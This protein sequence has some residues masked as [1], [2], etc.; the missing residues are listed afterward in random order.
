[1]FQV[2]IDF[3]TANTVAVVRGPD[4]NLQVKP[5]LGSGV[6]ATTSGHRLTGVDAERAGADDPA[7]YEGRLKRRVDDATVWLGAREYPVVDLIAAVLG[8]V[9]AQLPAEVEDAGPTGT[10]AP[11]P[12]QVVMTRPADWGRSRTQVLAEAAARAGLGPVTFVPEPVAAATYYHRTLGHELPPGKVLVV[13]DLGAGSSDVSIVR[14]T[15]GGYEVAG[16]AGLDNVGGLDLDEAIVAHVRHAVGAGNVPADRLGSPALREEVRRA[17]ERLAQRVTAD[18]TVPG[19]GAEVH[20]HRD[21]L[22]RIAGP[23]LDRTV[24]LT[25]SALQECQLTRA[26]VG[27]VFLVGGSSRIVLAAALLHSALGVTPTVV[28]HPELVLA[29]GA[30]LTLPGPSGRPGPPTVHSGRSTRERPQW[31]KGYLVAGVVAA[32]AATVG[33]VVWRATGDPAH[34][35]A[36]AS[37]AAPAGRTPLGQAP[38]GPDASAPATQPAGEPLLGHTGVVS[39][40]AFSPDGTVVLTGSD[41]RTARLWNRVENRVSTL[42]GQAKPVLGVAFDPKG[43]S[44]A[45]ADQDGSVWLWSLVN[46]K[47]AHK[48]AA[49]PAGVS[50]VAYSPDGSLIATGGADH[51]VQLWRTSDGAHV[52]T[53]T[54]HRLEVT[55]IAFNA[56]GTRLLSGSADGT[57]RLW[58]VSDGKTVRTFDGGDG[59]TVDGVAF[60]GAA[61]VATTSRGGMIRLW[62]AFSGARLREIAGGAFAVAFSP[63][64]TTLAAGSDDP[65]VRLWNASTGQL[66][67]TL[68][69]HTGGVRSLAFSRDGKKLVSGSADKSARLWDLTAV[70]G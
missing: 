45:T 14:A 37:T 36:P 58:R 9:R 50:C 69:G 60:G 66:V 33:I 11:G 46:L 34:G 44:V 13:V 40:V 67:G 18:I 10:R 16:T 21:E 25:L 65:P 39:G 63:D 26:D 32:V 8:A 42:S 7:G 2:G 55:S 52:R 54:G 38:A 64:G 12:A 22:E 70:T 62:N 43:R 49:G 56:D 41:D 30:V 47:P 20:L 5:V 31:K 3:G 23:Y 57:A 48:I 68:A 24:H 17:K 35:S 27:G 53:L 19:S 1:V 29:E 15:A 61:T 4:G 51:T 59:H 6:F 28:E